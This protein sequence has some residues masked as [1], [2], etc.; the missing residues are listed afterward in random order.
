MLVAGTRPIQIWHQQECPPQPSNSTP[1]SM[2][3]K[4]FPPVNARILTLSSLDLGLDNPA[5]EEMVPH[6]FGHV[7]IRL[8]NY[9]SI[10]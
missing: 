10:L 2:A 6:K 1:R 9:L 4:E 7:G 5:A 3:H 8:S